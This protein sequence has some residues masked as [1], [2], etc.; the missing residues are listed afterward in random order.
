VLLSWLALVPVLDLGVAHARR[1]LFTLDAV[2]HALVE[3][4]AG[5][6]GETNAVK[7]FH[8]IIK[9]TDKVYQFISSSFCI[10]SIAF[11]SLFKIS[12]TFEFAF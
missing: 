1:H 11:G 6:S 3:S 5:M 9:L 12:A 10:K 7:G 4:V 8:L 2:N